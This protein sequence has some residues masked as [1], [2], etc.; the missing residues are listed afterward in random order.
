MTIKEYFLAMKITL[1]I[2]L[3]SN[4]SEDPLHPYTVADAYVILEERFP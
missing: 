3:Q 4:Q 2:R 1:V